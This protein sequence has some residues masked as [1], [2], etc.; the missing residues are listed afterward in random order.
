MKKF[1]MVLL[2]MCY[3]CTY[4]FSTKRALIIGISEY[5]DTKWMMPRISAERDIVYV[6]EFLNKNGF[7]DSNITIL[8]NQKATKTA[9]VNAMKELAS[10][11]EI[12]DI[13]YIHF[14]GHGQLMSDIDGDENP[15]IFGEKWDESWIPYDASFSPDKYDN[16]ERHLCDDEVG[17]LLSSIRKKVGAHGEILVVIDACHSGDATR[18]NEDTDKFYETIGDSISYNNKLPVKRGTKSYF[19]IEH[20]SQSNKKTQRIKEDWI[21]ISACKSYQVN[22]EMQDAQGLRIGMLT[23]GLYSII[24]QLQS[25]T[26]LEL[27]NYLTKFMDQNRHPKSVVGQNPQITGIKNNHN[28]RNTFKSQ[29]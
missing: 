8:K 3:S 6:K 17:V 28:I 25:I 4:A 15:N 26:N 13:V 21:T 27:E 14:S 20:N 19:T 7:N 24:D 1:I 18:E 5:R 2:I 9:I 16:G 29:Q 22:S 11:S 12:G 23:Y 10:K